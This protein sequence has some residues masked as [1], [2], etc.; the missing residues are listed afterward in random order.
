MS[1]ETQES[2][3]I[4]PR[5]DEA[6]PDAAETDDATLG[7]TGEP[8]VVAEDFEA[9][10]PTR[11]L[12]GVWAIIVTTIAVALS[13][14]VLYATRATFSAQVYRTTFLGA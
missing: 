1:D 6:L 10:S 5:T 12:R 2:R 8:R 13:L 11:D 4:R 3:R 9:E 14:Y 7:A